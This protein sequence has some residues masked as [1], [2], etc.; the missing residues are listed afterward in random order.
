MND[1][2]DPAQLR[3]VDVDGIPTRLYEAGEGEPLVLIHGGYFG[4]LYSLDCWS[5]NLDALATSFRVVAFD[6]LGQGHTGNPGAPGEYTFDRVLGHALAL[7]DGLELGRFHL[8]GHSIGALVA[9]EVALARPQAI[10]TLVVVDTNTLAPDDARFPRGAFYRELESRIPPGPPTRESVRMEPD[11]QS[12][13]KDH[14]TDDFVAR[15]LEIALTPSFVEATAA[16]ERDRS[17]PVWVPTLEAAR[18]HALSAIDAGG[19]AFPAL[20]VWGAND[21]S[22]PLPLGQALFD[23]VAAAT[24][25]AEL[26]VLARAGHYCFREHP[27]A[28]ERLLAGFCA[29]RP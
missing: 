17:D 12:F 18:A 25:E 16:R 4:S 15:L 21:V 8:V 14:V 10:R 27:E 22:A 28:F 11:E 1:R 2:L 24:G 9:A 7:L 29:G 26:H 6:R 19:F 20:V 23:R 13:S 5:L 3:T